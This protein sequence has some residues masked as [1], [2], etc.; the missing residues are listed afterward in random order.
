MIL[1]IGTVW[2]IP[3]SWEILLAE[4]SD[5]MTYHVLAQDWNR[6]YGEGEIFEAEILFGDPECL[7][8]EETLT[9]G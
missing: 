5:Y 7:Q 3:D 4:R 8:M 1:F 2:D 6:S 9:I